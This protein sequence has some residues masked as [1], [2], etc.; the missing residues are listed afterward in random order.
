MLAEIFLCVLVLTVGILVAG[1]FYKTESESSHEHAD[2]SPHDLRPRTVADTRGGRTGMFVR[3]SAGT[4]RPGAGYDA[5]PARRPESIRPPVGGHQHSRTGASPAP[6]EARRASKNRHVR[7]RLLLLVTIPAVA[8]AVIALCVGGLTNILQGTRI[9][10]PVGSVR[11]GAILSALGIGVVMILVLVLAAWF[12]MVTA[13][14]VLQPL[15][16]LRTRALETVGARRPDAAR[17]IGENEGENAPSDGDS[18]DVDSPDEI[19][20]VAR[21]VKAMRAELLRMAANEAALH[22]KLDV[23]FVNL[24]N[25]SKSLV[26]R[27]IRLIESLEHSERDRD[28]LAYLSRMNRIATRMHRNSQNLLVLAGHE[29]SSGWNQPMPLMNVIRA[30]VSEVE[31][32]ERVSLHPQPDIAVSGPV[33][34]DAVHLL[35]ELTENAT[36]FSAVDMPVEISGYLSNSGGVVIGITDRGVGMS[37]NELAHANWRLENPPAADIDVPKWIGVFVV[38]RLAARHGIRVRLQQAEFG[39]LTALVWL[40]DEVIIHQGADASPRLSALGRARPRPGLHEAAVAPGHATAEQRVTT[41]RSAEFAPPREDVRDPSLGR[42]LLADA[43]RRPGPTWSASSPRPAFQAEPPATVRPSGLG[44]PDAMGEY[45]GV[46]GQEAQALGNEAAR[47]IADGTFGMDRFSGPGLSAPSDSET[48]QV[49]STPVGTAAPLNQET[50][51][52]DGSVIVPPAEG[53]A[54]PRRL[55]IFDSVESHWFRGGRQ[56]PGSSGGNAA[57]GSRWS[58]PADE[59]WHAAETV[60]SPSSSGSTAAGLPR[61]QPSANLVPGAIPSTQ[62]VVPTRSAAAARDRLAGFQQGVSQGRAAA[63]ETTGPGGEDES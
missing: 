8:V 55:P 2:G 27:Q 33:V 29:L 43:G 30:A 15:Y 11:D 42:R 20:D 61:R 22:G 7:S 52:A 9:N 44:L 4:P 54:E 57:A 13:R 25:R 46:S 3:E 1:D 59:G 31:E 58:S 5:D 48:S 14:S 53:L 62:P 47:D 35:A 16:R 38:A 51:S 60:D 17:R 10:S 26:E 50:S 19:G 12:T 39:G 37:A 56:V 36:S 34:N 45:A 40:P 23:M 49:A 28:R 24:S 18:V 32:S 6:G 41:A 21:A 63:S